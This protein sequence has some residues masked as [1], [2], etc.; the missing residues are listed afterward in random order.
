MVRDYRF[1]LG[2]VALMQGDVVVVLPDLLNEHELDS[3][4]VCIEA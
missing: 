2:G 4:W 1:D 3:D